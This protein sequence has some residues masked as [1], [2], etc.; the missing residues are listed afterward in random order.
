M[1]LHQPSSTRAAVK[2]RHVSRQRRS[3]SVPKGGAGRHNW[4][5]DLADCE[6]VDVPIEEPFYDDQVDLD[7]LRSAN[8][9]KEEARV[10]S[11]A[12]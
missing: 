2:D 6:D 3:H 8:N 7:L 12:L 5:N 4:G 9:F 10:R 11:E 1:T